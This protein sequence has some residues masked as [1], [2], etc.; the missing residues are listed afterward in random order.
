[1]STFLKNKE[2]QLINGGYLSDKAGNPVSNADFITAQKHAEYI[3]TFANLAK[4]K[5]FK[6]KQADT[7]SSLKAEVQKYLNDQRPTTFI[8]KPKE[9]KRPVSESLAKEAL[10]FIDFQETSSK[11]D[12]INNFLQQFTILKEF[13]E[14]GLFFEQGII[15][16]N[17]IY[18]IEEVTIAVESVIELLDK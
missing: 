14:F 12:K 5:D 6:G 1:M 18:T 4:G 11:V 17:K 2:L 3:I 10:A 9:V 13:S 8:E 15:K 16:L 7:L